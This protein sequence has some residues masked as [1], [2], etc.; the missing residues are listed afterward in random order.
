MV[1]YVSVNFQKEW[2]LR[3]LVIGQVRTGHLNQFPGR[4][5]STSWLHQIT[6]L[7]VLLSSLVISWHTVLLHQWAWK[8]KCFKGWFSSTPPLENLMQENIFYMPQTNS[9]GALPMQGTID[10]FLSILIGAMNLIF[11]SSYKASF[12]PNKV[13]L[14]HLLQCRIFFNLEFSIEV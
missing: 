10:K 7:L 14:V 2:I 13:S 9:G 11:Q 5:K 12:I 8:S 3:W 1:E 4:D 6:I